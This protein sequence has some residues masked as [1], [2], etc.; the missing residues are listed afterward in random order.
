MN[1]VIIEDEHLTA[2][3]ILTLLQGID[4]E[5]RITA[6]LDSVKSSVQ[7]F[8]QHEKP[9]LVFMDIQLADGLSFEIF[10]QVRMDCPV[11][12]LTAYQE[13]AI[14]AFKVNSVD[15]LLKPVSEEEMR[16]ALTKYRQYFSLRQGPPHIEK[17]LLESI[18]QMI[19]S[20]YKSRFMVKVG[21]RIRSVETK[22]ILYFFS[23]QKGTFMHTNE[24]RNYVIDFTLDA[25][26]DLLD[27][28]QFHRINRQY[29][30]SHTAISELITL[31]GS[32]LKVNLLHSDDKEI[33]ISRERIQPFKQWLDQ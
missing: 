14:K 12:F 7:W 33:Y 16:I 1:V 28:V 5:I 29:I 6:I 25:L 22:D 18:R 2:D 27:P 4:P 21:E 31:S 9:D 20:P 19:S 32:K 13:Y 24:N 17:E 3:R 26:T 30:I 8:L 23:L 10:D 15:Y 11:I